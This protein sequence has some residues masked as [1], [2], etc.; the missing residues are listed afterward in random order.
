MT[1]YHRVIKTSSLYYTYTDTCVHILYT[2][3]LNITYINVYYTTIYYICYYIMYSLFHVSAAWPR[4]FVGS[5][6]RRS[7]SARSFSRRS[8]PRDLN[9]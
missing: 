8:R 6:G 4:S 5:D 1:G 7:A 9:S 2:I 3:D